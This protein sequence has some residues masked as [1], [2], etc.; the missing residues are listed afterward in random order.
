MHALQIVFRMVLCQRIQVYYG[1][2]VIVRQPS[3]DRDQLVNHQISSYA[4]GGLAVFL[5]KDGGRKHDEQLRQVR[6]VAPQ[7]KDVR[8]YSTHAH[9]EALRVP[10]AVLGVVGTKH[11][12]EGPRS[13]SQRA[14]QQSGL[15]V[16]FRA[17]LPCSSAVYPVV[18]D[19]ILFAQHPLQHEGPGVTRPCGGNAVSVGY[20]VAKAGDPVFRISVVHGTII[21]QTARR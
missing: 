15:S 7:P 18:Q 12:H 19:F 20:A 5:R 21:P 14:V 6:S 1:Q 4:V 16:G 11:Q 3:D 10:D 8:Y 17:V 2:A 13:G 9:L